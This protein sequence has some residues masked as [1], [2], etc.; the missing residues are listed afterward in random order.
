MDF[1]IYFTAKVKDGV[2]EGLPRKKMKQQ[3]LHFEGKQVEV[4]VRRVKKTRSSQQ[5]RLLWLYFQILGDYLGYSKQEMHNIIQ[6]K[7]LKREKVDETTGEVFQ[8]LAGTSNL[9]TLEFAELFEEIYNWSAETFGV[10][11]PKPGEQIKMDV[12]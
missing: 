7:F 4:I 3:L 10:I 11:L 12:E 1:E 5:N 6:F 2:L 9:T 8:Y